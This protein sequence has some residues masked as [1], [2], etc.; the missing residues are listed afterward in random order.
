MKDLTKTKAPLKYIVILLCFICL[1]CALTT[2]VVAYLS[3]ADNS[4]NSF[5]IGGNTIELVEEFIPPKELAPGVVIKKDVSVTNTGLNDCY[6]RVMAVFTNSDMGDWCTV[7]WNTGA[8]WV[9]NQEDGYW[10]YPNPISN[11]ETT[12]SLFTTITLSEDIPESLVKDFDMI[13]Y[14]ESYQ[15]ADSEDYASA[16]EGYKANKKDITGPGLYVTYPTGKTAENPMWV[17]NG[18]VAIS[19]I[20]SDVSGV[21]SLVVNGNE[22]QLGEYESNWDTEIEVTSEDTAEIVVVATDTV[23]NSTS[24][25]KYVRLDSNSPSLSVRSIGSESAN[26]PTLYGNMTYKVVGSAVDSESGLKSVTVNGSIATVNEDG[27]WEVSTGLSADEVT[28]INITATDNAGNASEINKYVDY[29]DFVNE[30]PCAITLAPANKWVHNLDSVQ[31]SRSFVLTDPYEVFDLVIFEDSYIPTGNEI[32][33]W[34]AGV[35]CDSDGYLNNG[36]MCYVTEHPS[37]P[38]KVSLVIAG[39]GA[40]KIYADSDFSGGFAGFTNVTDF[41]NL[42]ILDTSKVT[43]M[44][45]MFENCSS[46]TG[47]DLSKFNTSAVTTTEYMFNSCSGLS[48]LDLSSFSTS[49]ITNMNSMFSGCNSLT[50]LNTVGWDTA[51][52]STMVQMFDSCSSLTEIQGINLWATPSLTQFSNMFIGCSSLQTLDLSCFITSGVTNYEGIFNGC[53]S[54]TIIDLSSWDVLA[55]TSFEGMFDGTDAVTTAYAYTEA[56]AAILNSVD[57]KPSWEFVVKTA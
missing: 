35:D 2:G 34:P 18:T 10:Y 24:V 3:D 43:N 53:S 41:V 27:S 50:S 7:D 40:G 5:I 22:V 26:N 37:Y 47:L 55:G 14:A 4:D 13:V 16:W 23:G 29:C 25:T 30:D 44:N 6:V 52:V 19:G 54:L 49:S 17:N 32:T 33:S 46:L 11:G 9:Y 39:S 45:R 42:G 1:S 56:D 36:I 57:G 8:G 48:S 12:P 15:S 31:I 51:S 20:V 28:E 38:G 21:A